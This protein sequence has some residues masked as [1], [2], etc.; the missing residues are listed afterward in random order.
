VKKRLKMKPLKKHCYQHAIY[1]V[2]KP[3]QQAFIKAGF[4]II[5]KIID[6]ESEQ[7][8]NQCCMCDGVA[9][10]MYQEEVLKK[11]LE[12]C[13]GERSVLTIYELAKKALPESEE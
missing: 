13:T 5:E 6:E 10:S 8:I 7:A 11:I 9:K 4:D 12:E 2:M 1:Q 3:E